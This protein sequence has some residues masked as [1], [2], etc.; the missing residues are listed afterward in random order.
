MRTVLILFSALTLGSVLWRVF[1]HEWNMTPFMALALFAGARLSGAWRYALPLGGMV[2]A[3]LVLGFHA[4]MIWVYGAMALV[5]FLGGALTGRPLTWYL[6]GALAGSVVFYLVSN[7][8]VWVATD[9]YASNLA[10]LVACYVAALPFL[11]KS[12][13]ADLFF[14]VIFFGAFAALDQRRASMAT[15]GNT[16]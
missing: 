10:G 2:L 9:L 8:G 14:T 16:V 4:T 3:D 7:M 1:P 12:M 6:G 15:S 5:V 13:A 11:L